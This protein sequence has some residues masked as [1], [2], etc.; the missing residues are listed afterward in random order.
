M[1]S[2]NLLGILLHDNVTQGNLAIP[3][4]G[5]FSLM[6]DSQ[7]G[8]CLDSFLHFQALSGDCSDSP[9]KLRNILENLVNNRYLNP[10]TL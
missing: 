2:A 6:P 8:R 5:Y 10:N 9:C 3:A 7:N 4:Q 1:Q